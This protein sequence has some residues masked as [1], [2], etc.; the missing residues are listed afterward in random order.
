MFRGLAMP[1]LQE[2]K[3]RASR[4]DQSRL[5]AST[6][7]EQVRG[8]LREEAKRGPAVES[9]AGPGR[10]GSGSPPRQLEDLAVAKRRD[11]CGEPDVQGADEHLG[12]HALPER[13]DVSIVGQEQ[14][15][16]VVARTGAVE[17]PPQDQRLLA[18]RQVA[19]PRHDVE[20]GEGDAPV[21]QD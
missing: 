14:V 1:T 11:A 20:V 9:G 6:E 15:L 13:S 2:V 8:L 7:T 18:R 3:E 10:A 19:D 17:L 5:A 12:H 4:T 16:E 21:A